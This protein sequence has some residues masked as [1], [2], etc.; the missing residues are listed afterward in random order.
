MGVVGS[1]ATGRENVA[2]WQ[3]L[4]E[5]PYDDVRLRLAASLQERVRGRTTTIHQGELD[6][7][8]LRFL[9]ASVL[10]NVQR[11][12]RTKPL[13]VTQMVR[14]L[15]RKPE[16]AKALLPILAVALRSVRGPEWRAGLAGVVGLMQRR[17]DLASAV[18]QSFP[19]LKWS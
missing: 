3:R 15:E 17:P 6:A 11:G 5:S 18:N 19:E 12:G 10:L 16:E 9:W 13:V 8:L 14:R 4:L 7:E 2:L 1:G